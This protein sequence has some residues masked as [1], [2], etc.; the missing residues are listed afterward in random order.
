MKNILYPLLFVL[1]LTGCN[2]KKSTKLPPQEKHIKNKKKA[3][4]LGGIWNLIKVD[5]TLF[6]IEKVYGY[7][8]DQPNLKIEPNIDRISGYSG[9]NS[10]GAVAKIGKSKILLTQDIEAT[11]QG[12]GG[13]IWEN[14][15]Y[16]RL[17][18][19]KL[20]KYNT[21]T[22][23]IS[24]SGE[25][26]MTFLRRHLH[27]LEV[28]SWE[29][30]KVNDTIF[31]IKKE[32]NSPNEPQPVISFNFEK[33]QVAGWNGCNSFGLEIDFKE[34]HYTSGELF[35]DARGCYEG[36]LE[37]FY[38]IL[39]DNKSFEIKNDN[40]MLMNSNGNTMEFKKLE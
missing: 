18:D 13:N 38:G 22:L 29:L 39:G 37:K 11:Q 10:Y 35:S 31:D 15:Y 25:R 7:E 28:N 34:D 2:Q 16:S 26:S 33:N 30:V 8:T 3:D 12:C 4:S 36:W 9:C 1:V 32:Y 19:I 40:L 17:A 6:N 23:W 5:D 24:N 20:V 21:D 27:P 14:D